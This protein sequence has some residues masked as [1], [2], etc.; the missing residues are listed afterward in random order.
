MRVAVRAQGPVP[1]GS[2]VSLRQLQCGK[3]PE[4]SCDHIQ[5]PQVGHHGASGTA[6]E[7]SLPSRGLRSSRRAPEH[8]TYEA[9]IREPGAEPDRPTGRVLR[10]GMAT[11]TL[12]RGGTCPALHKSQEWGSEPRGAGGR[13]R[14]APVATV[15]FRQEG[16]RAAGSSAYACSV[17][18][19]HVHQGKLWGLG[20]GPLGTHR[21][22]SSVL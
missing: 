8:S 22:F 2:P 19:Y 6:G 4:G 12:Q 5:G 9:R 7:P 11:E 14:W 21:I 16:C 3:Q 10:A 15:A 13:T 18:V 20:A 1:A 17:L